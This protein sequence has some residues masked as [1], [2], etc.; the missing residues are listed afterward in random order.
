MIQPVRKPKLSETVA[1][2]LLALIRGGTYPAGSRL[3]PER[4]LSR[5]FNISRAS[6]RDAFR[7]LELLGHVEIRQGDGTYVRT[8]DGETLSLPFRGLLTG[9]PQAALDLLEFRR[10]LEPEVAALAAVRV[11]PEHAHAFAESL[12]RQREALGR[13][14]R[15]SR[16]D[17]AFH[18]LISQTAGNLVTLQ[19]LGTL[20]SLLSELRTSA[21]PGHFPALTLAQHERIARAILAGDPAGARAAMLDHLNAVVETSSLPLPL[22]ASTPA[23]TPAS[24]PISPSSRPP[25]TPSPRPD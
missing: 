12:A 19:V 8:P 14:E 6:L 3:P 20:R 22:S 24:A 15:L 7:H 11:R 25:T 2:E 1:D 23:S 5:R 17:L 4:E 9:R 13:G 21:L 18:A 10:M 16:E